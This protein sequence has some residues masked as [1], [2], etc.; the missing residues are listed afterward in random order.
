MKSIQLSCYCCGIFFHKE[1]KEYNRRLK[2]KG[3]N[4][5]SF[6]SLSCAAI[7]NNSPRKNPLLTKTC[8]CGN[9]FTTNDPNIYNC[10]RGCASRF[11]YNE[12]RRAIFLNL[13]KEGKL[14]SF[15]DLNN[16]EIT[17]ITSNSLRVR[18]WE[19]YDSLHRYLL[20][21]DV[22]HHF[23]YVIPGTN[24]V[25]DLALFDLS[26]LIEFDESHHNSINYILDDIDKD[27]IARQNGWNIIRIKVELWMKPFPI[28]L[29]S[30]IIESY[31]N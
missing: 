24:R 8:Q 30:Q 27:N 11:S 18:E 5:K 20:Y 3:Q 26:L 16:S 14:T 12:N 22:P 15:S 17:L 21:S 19:K 10:S 31:Y 4:L 28:N 1:I 13:F 2:L 6:C 23:E 9:I 7:D 25:Y 29:I